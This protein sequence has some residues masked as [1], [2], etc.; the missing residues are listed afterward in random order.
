MSILADIQKLPGH[1]FDQ[2]ALTDP[3]LSRG[4]DYTISRGSFQPFSDAV[5]ALIMDSV[6][7]LTLI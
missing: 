1:S 7:N 2:P 5:N 3:A 4:L 6:V